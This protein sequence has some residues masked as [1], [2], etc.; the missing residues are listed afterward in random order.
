MT[1][2]ESKHLETIGILQQHNARLARQVQR[3]HGRLNAIQ[4]EAQCALKDELDPLDPHVIKQLASVREKPE[5]RETACS[6]LGIQLALLGRKLAKEHED[7]CTPA[8]LATIYMAGV[9]MNQ[10]E[11]AVAYRFQAAAEMAALTRRFTAF[12]TYLQP[13]ITPDQLHA[14]TRPTAMC[15]ATIATDEEWRESA[16]VRLEQLAAAGPGT[17]GHREARYLQVLLR[18]HSDRCEEQAREVTSA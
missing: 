4:F 18:E 14:L 15:E 13:T 7:I 11:Q 16:L 12:A 17:F 2:D 9:V 5:Q 10:A 1:D 6:L 8:E 3:L